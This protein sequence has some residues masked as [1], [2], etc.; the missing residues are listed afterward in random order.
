M[1]QYGRLET[2]QH[3]QQIDGYFLWTFIGWD[4]NGN[5]RRLGC[6]VVNPTSKK[7][8]LKGQDL[9]F[10]RATTVLCFSNP[11]LF[12]SVLVSIVDSHKKAPSHAVALHI[13]SLTQRSDLTCPCPLPPSNHLPH[14]PY[15]SSPLIHLNLPSATTGLPKYYCANIINSLPKRPKSQIHDSS[16]KLTRECCLEP[17]NRAHAA[18]HASTETSGGVVMNQPPKWGVVWGV[19]WFVEEGEGKGKGKGKGGGCRRW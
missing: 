15:T 17:I 7:L 9:S 14:H 11:S 8:F 16:N 1:Y 3:L 19:G 18:P 2:S 12:Q 5:G 10:R 6:D 4:Y 13:S